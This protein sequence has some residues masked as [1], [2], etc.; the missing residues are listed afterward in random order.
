MNVIGKRTITD[1]INNWL[2]HGERGASSETIVSHLTGIN[3]AKHPSHPCDP[4]DFY[5]CYQLVEACPE[6]K[7]ELQLV[8][9]ISPTWQKIIENWD[10]LVAMLLVT[11]EQENKTGDNDGNMYVFMKSLGC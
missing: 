9:S 1:N 4:S 6:I 3:I 10:T 5:R 11:E 8:K 7:A 2:A